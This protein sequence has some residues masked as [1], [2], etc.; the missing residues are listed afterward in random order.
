MA[1]GAATVQSD[2]ALE[3]AMEDPFAGDASIPAADVPAN[4]A[5]DPFGTPPAADA[6]PFGTPPAGDADP[7]G[8][9]GGAEMEDPFGGDPFGS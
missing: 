3:G 6:D 2:D 9:G 5:A 7:F 4:D 1:A 8:G